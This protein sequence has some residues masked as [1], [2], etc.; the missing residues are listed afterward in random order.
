MR[1]QN[2]HPDRLTPNFKSM[3]N[4]YCLMK[5]LNAKFCVKLAISYPSYSCFYLGHEEYK[6]LFEI[7]NLVKNK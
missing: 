5:R 7:V 2:D 4:K 3:R 6:N 1:F